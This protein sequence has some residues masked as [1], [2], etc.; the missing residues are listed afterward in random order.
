M[1]D[2]AFDVVGIGNAIVDI[3]ARCDD[4]FLDQQGLAKGHMQLVD[5][6]AATS[7]YNAIGPAV[8]ISGGSA[9]NTI[10]GV[11]SFGGSA[12]YIGKVADDDFGRV[13]AHD[14]KA[15]GVSF[16][17]QPAQSETPTARSIVLVTPD[18]ER[19]MSTYLGISPELN[20]SE[21]DK[22][23]IAKSRILYLEGYL[24]DAPQAMEAFRLAAQIAKS[25]DCEV[26]L[27]LS[28]GFCVDRHRSEF[29]TFIKDDIDILFANESEIL[30]LYETQSLETALD[31]VSRDAK[32]AA[33]TRSEKGSVIVSGTERHEAKA[34]AI[35]EVADT[36][37]AGDLYAAGFLFGRARNMTLA[38]SAHLGHVAAAEIISHIGARPETSLRDFARQSGIEI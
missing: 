30:S 19:T 37:G 15:S 29:L 2:T 21:V 35:S 33:V 27:T 23:V 3:I 32:L 34:E 24:F 1:T 11:A 31:N 17:T 13:F 22:D 8:E 38:Q 36:T 4:A 14:I 26:S 7:L 5:R 10:A 9:A 25:S 28:D 6:D 16:A 12:A 20:S 18:A